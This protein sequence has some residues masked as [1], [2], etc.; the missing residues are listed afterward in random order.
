[1][2][3]DEEWEDDEIDEDGMFLLHR[4]LTRL[5]RAVHR[6]QTGERLDLD[7]VG[8]VE[9]DEA[10]EV[11]EVGEEGPVEEDGTR[12]VVTAGT[13]VPSASAA[14]EERAKQAGGKFRTLS[15]RH[16]K[17]LERLYPHLYK[18]REG[19]EEGGAASSSHL[20]EL[21]KGL[22]WQQLRSEVKHTYLQKF[23]RDVDDDPV[24]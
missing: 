6:H 1:L 16:H 14:S 10:G 8:E 19:A 9:G 7:E 24:L 22:L 2:D 15:R 18:P 13:G 23:G 12:W 21:E 17:M 11:G 5:N 20:S 4:N 3:A